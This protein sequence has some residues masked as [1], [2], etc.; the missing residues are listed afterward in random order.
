MSHPYQTISVDLHSKKEK[1]TDYFQYHSHIVL[2]TLDHCIIGHIDKVEFYHDTI[3]VLDCKLAV[4]F[5]FDSNGKFLSKI[6]KKGASS[7]EYI[8]ASDFYIDGANRLYIYDGMQGAVLL[9]DFQG[10]YIERAK[11]EKGYSFTKSNDGNWIF[12]LGNGSASPDNILYYNLLIYN[13]NFEPIAKDLP[14]NKS[15][16]GFRHTVISVKSVFFNDEDSVY[17]LPLLS[18]YVFT[19]QPVSHQIQAAYKIDFINHPVKYLDENMNANS[20]KIYLQEIQNTTI[21]SRINNFC[22][23]KNLVFFHFVYE[24]NWWFCV[25][26]ESEGKT[27]L[28]DFTFDENGLPFNPVNYY[29]DNK[30]DKALNIVAGDLFEAVKE[31]DDTNNEIIS[32]IARSINGIDDSN[33]ILVFYTLKKDEN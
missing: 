30:K 14:Y 11:V 20:V 1:S 7:Q 21:P 15:M 19:Y 22:K 10:N 33:P 12:Y 26:N 29:S 8:D 2:E 23:I 13:E 9:Y 24:K 25:Y 16:T 3:F 31:L 18:N 6:D 17:I 4:V 5:L 32:D 27:A 28:C